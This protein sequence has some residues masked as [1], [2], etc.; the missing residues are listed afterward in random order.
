[1]RSSMSPSRARQG[2]AFT[3]AAP[4]IAR[5]NFNIPITPVPRR[6]PE[7][8]GFADV[9]TLSADADAGLVLFLHFCW[10][11]NHSYDCENFRQLRSS[12]GYVSVLGT[13]FHCKTVSSD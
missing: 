8:R 3:T 2:E 4:D 10:Q 6:A 13:R 9:K 7:D 12:P 1:M 5:H 11:T